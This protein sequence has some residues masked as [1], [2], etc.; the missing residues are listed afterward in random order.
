MLCII[1]IVVFT[2]RIPHIDVH[3]SA[4][5][6][7]DIFL[8][9]YDYKV[10]FHL[11]GILFVFLLSVSFLALCLFSSFCTG[12]LC[13]PFF[14]FLYSLFRFFVFPYLL[15]LILAILLWC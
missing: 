13:R 9:V 14:A 2:L 12:V 6:L 11:L 1:M 5:R 15:S 3:P 8:F 10:F 4:Y 7:V